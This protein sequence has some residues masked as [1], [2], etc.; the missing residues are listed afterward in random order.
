MEK[1]KK[2]I[3]IANDLDTAGF[4]DEASV[5]D[6]IIKKCWED[7]MVNDMFG[8]SGSGSVG[9]YSIFSFPASQN[10]EDD[11]KDLIILEEDVEE[12]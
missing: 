7:K 3:K 9:T 6:I 10:S 8:G 5:L 1:V 12:Q 4:I 2:L 11:E